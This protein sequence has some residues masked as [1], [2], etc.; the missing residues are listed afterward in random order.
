MKIYLLAKQ[1]P[2]L[3]NLSRSDRRK[4]WRH[5]YW[6]MLGFWQLWAGLAALIVFAIL[7][8]IIGLVLWGRFGFSQTVSYACA[9]VG[10]LTGCL[11]DG[12]IYCAIVIE[13]L[14]PRFRDYIAANKISN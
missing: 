6:D 2:E 1:I 3:A 4:V 9:L 12:W 7:G 14:R 5:C 10:G 11:I 13:R 8:D